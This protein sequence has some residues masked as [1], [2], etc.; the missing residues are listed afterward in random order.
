M[1]T[2]HTKKCSG[3]RG[4]ECTNFVH[5][6]SETLPN[7]YVGY[8]ANDSYKR[9][10]IATDPGVTYINPAIFKDPKDNIARVLCGECM[11][12]IPW[13]P[14]WCSQC[15]LFDYTESFKIV[16]RPVR[17]MIIY[18]PPGYIPFSRATH[19]TFNQ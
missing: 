9:G 12:R 10:E 6:E 4:H 19:N 18:N 13:T 17:R 1:G 16:R 2:Q 14:R 15:E 3:F 8:A 11:T 5:I 7:F